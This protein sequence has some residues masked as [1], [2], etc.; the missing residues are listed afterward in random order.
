MGLT[1]NHLTSVDMNKR[2][3]DL[4][5]GALLDK[6]YSYDKWEFYAVLHDYIKHFHP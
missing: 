5:L 2:S 6:S 4:Q 3:M 1:F